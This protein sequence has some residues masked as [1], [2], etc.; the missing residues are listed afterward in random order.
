M[1]NIKICGLCTIEHALAAI[2]AGADWLG[3]VFALSRRQLTTAQALAIVTAIRQ[4]PAGQRVRLVGLFVN[5]QPAQINKL[6]EICDLDYIQL[7]GNEVLAQAKLLCRP[8]IKAVRLNRQ[9]T[10][11]AWLEA[12]QATVAQTLQFAP[13]PLLIDA[14]LPGSYGG[15]GMLADWAQAAAWAQ[16]LPITLAGGLNPANVASAITQVQPWGVDVSSGVEQDGTKDIA[17]I[18]A[19]IKAVRASS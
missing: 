6:A 16:R 5:E 8:V 7:S 3:L 13:S 17:L 19:F 14:H 1:T 11:N 10:E 12:A 4:H 18:Q 2:E 15:T 9:A